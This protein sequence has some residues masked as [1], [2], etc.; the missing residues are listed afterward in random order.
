MAILASTALMLAISAPLWETQ[1]A[2]E[3]WVY[4]T[5]SK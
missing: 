1:L 4:L 2:R 5:G 3:M